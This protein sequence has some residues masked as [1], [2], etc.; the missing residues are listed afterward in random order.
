MEQQ[1]VTVE[2]H[3]HSVVSAYSYLIGASSG[4]GSGPMVGADYSDVTVELTFDENTTEA[5]VDISIIDDDIVEDTE[6][7]SV[8]LATDDS[9]VML[10]PDSAIVNILDQDR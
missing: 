5:C 7:F 6:D 10:E 9:A 1:Q 2:V 8:T 3:D 4:S